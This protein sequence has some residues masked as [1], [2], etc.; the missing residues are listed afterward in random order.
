MKIGSLAEKLKS[1]IIDDNQN[2]TPA[3]KWTIKR[4]ILNVSVQILKCTLYFYNHLLLKLLSKIWYHNK[5]FV[6]KLNLIN[7]LEC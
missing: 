5:Q 1:D 3:K 7:K 4:K 2:Y 6:Y